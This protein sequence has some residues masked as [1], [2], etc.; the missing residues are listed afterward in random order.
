MDQRGTN[1]EPTEWGGTGL[2][3]D[4]VNINANYINYIQS[5]PKLV[6]SVE[7]LAVAD[8]GTTGHYRTLNSPCCNKRK[9][10]HPLP[11]QMPNGEIITSTHTALLNHQDLTFQDR[12]SHLFSRTQEGSVFHWDLLLSW[13]WI[14]LYQQFSPHQEQAEWTDH[15]GG[16][17]RCAH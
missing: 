4:I 11:I 10:I 9:A 1:G 17:K 6:L 12:Q 8:T 5:N 7:D 15:H 13:L 14:H 16:N 2:D 3:K